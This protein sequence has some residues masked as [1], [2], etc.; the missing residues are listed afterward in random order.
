MLTP[1]VDTG[2][3][4]IPY[5]TPV[6]DRNP[7]RRREVAIGPKH[8]ALHYGLALTHERAG[9]VEAAIASHREAL[10]LQPAMVHAHGSLGL[11]LVRDGRPAAARRHLRIAA[12][13]MPESTEYRDTLA[14]A[15]R[16]LGIRSPKGAPR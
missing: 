12:E 3:D 5:P 9:E 14:E 8:G 15:E 6:V 13:A 7:E 2:V 16:A 1:R 10:R 4:S 11:L